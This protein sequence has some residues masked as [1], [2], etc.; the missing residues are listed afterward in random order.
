MD[1][2]TPNKWIDL[3][4]ADWSGTIPATLII[5]K[6]KGYEKFVEGEMTWKQLE[7]AVKAGM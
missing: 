4:S 3:V 2:P 6:R 7:E 1:E 5:S